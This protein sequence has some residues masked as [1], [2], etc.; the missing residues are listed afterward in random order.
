MKKPGFTI[1]VIIG[2]V[3]LLSGCSL[4][5]KK[6]DQ[7]LGE[8]I[9]KI[10]K[11]DFSNISDFEEKKD[12]SQKNKK[13]VDLKD[14]SNED[15]EKINKWL[16]DNNYNRYGDPIDTMYSG[17]TPLFNEITGESVDRFEYII[18]KRPEVLDLFK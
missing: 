6:I 16:E 17:G 13:E 18:K 1:F 5:L 15:K 7:K 10:K 3:F 4:D 11:E 9:E 8:G 2:F 12:E 14:L